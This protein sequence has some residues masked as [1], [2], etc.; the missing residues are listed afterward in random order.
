MGRGGHA[1]TETPAISVRKLCFSRGGR[2][3]L[4]SVD[5]SIG[6]GTFVALVGANGA[7]KT[8]LMSLLAGLEAPTSG[9]IRV[10]DQRVSRGHNPV[11]ASIGI[12]F[13]DLALDLDLSVR[14][15]MRYSASLHGL[16]MSESDARTAAELRRFGLEDRVHERV[17]RLSGGQR[18]QIEISRALLHRPSVLLLD[19]A[20]TGLD[21]PTRRGLLASVRSLCRDRGLAVLWATHL[22]DELACADYAMALAAG[23]LSR[24]RDGGGRPHT[25]ADAD[26]FEL[27]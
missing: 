14:E 13:Q 21:P 25:G 8:T 2:T 18:R 17:R 10:L 19:E 5:F 27:R 26:G 3:I 24:F 16:S 23:R 7:G 6:A 9:E 11:L 1:M 22:L 12:V 4:D 20:S 15:N